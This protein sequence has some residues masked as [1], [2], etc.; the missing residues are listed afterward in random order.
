[1][2]FAL[3]V[4]LFHQ[5]MVDLSVRPHLMTVPNYRPR[6]FSENGGETARLNV[7][8]NT[9]RPYLQDR[10]I[11]LAE[12]GHF[13]L[14]P[15]VTLSNTLPTEDASMG[16]IMKRVME[17]EEYMPAFVHEEEGEMHMHN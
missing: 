12:I 15:D 17:W 3:P 13:S 8:I 4:G 5:Q 16:M 10:P 9:S 1:M 2:K 7:L 6:L 14:E 11:L